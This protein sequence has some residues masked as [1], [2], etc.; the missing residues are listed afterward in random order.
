MSDTVF[1]ADALGANRIGQLSSAQLSELKAGF[2]RKH[3][4]LTG[5]VGRAFDPLSKDL[6][7][8]QV[9][10]IEGAITKER[11]RVNVGAAIPRYR[12]AVASRDAGRQECRSP[13]D[14]YEFA[15]RT[16]M[17]RLFYL[18]YSRFIVN[19]ELLPDAVTDE[20]PGGWM[21]AH[22]AHDKVG[23]AMAFAQVAALKREQESYMPKETFSP[24]QR[25]AP[26]VLQ[27]AMRGD[28]E[29]PFLKLSFREDSTLTV[30]L[31]DGSDHEGTWSVDAE[32][33]LRTDAM[34]APVVADATVDADELTLFFEDRA[35][36]LRRP[37]GA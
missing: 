2:H 11:Q 6:K 34:G 27:A 3:S 22:K 17:V 14:I 4:G 18:P 26:A 7:A 21:A 33:R 12:I 25:A 8:G 36:K 35:L 32:S 23:E 1:S 10:S 5:L 31:P 16:G 24:D 15:P 29:N 9:E 37:T 13:L 30:R 19:L 28:W 20:V